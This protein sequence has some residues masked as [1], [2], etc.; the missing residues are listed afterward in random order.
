MSLCL[1][2][3]TNG[4]NVF[5]FY[6]YKW[7]NTDT[8]TRRQSISLDSLV[9]E[10]IHFSNLLIRQAKWNFIRENARLSYSWNR[11]IYI[12]KP[13]IIILLWLICTNQF[14][15][16]SMGHMSFSYRFTS[17][18]YIYLSYVFKYF[19]KFCKYSNIFLFALIPDI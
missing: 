18:L 11:K 13:I 9:N 1:I 17:Y 8:F 4:M 16:F 14:S 7:F 6:I 10:Y 15:A 2:N 19:P 3:Q 5:K 12:Y